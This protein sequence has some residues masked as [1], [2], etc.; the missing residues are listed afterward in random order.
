MPLVLIAVGCVIAVPGAA[1]DRTAPRGHAAAP[2]QT[3]RSKSIAR[4]SQFA[5][6]TPDGS[7]LIELYKAART[8]A[9][10]EGANAKVKDQVLQAQSVTSEL[11][12]LHAAKMTACEDVDASHLDAT[13]AKATAFSSTL[14]RIEHEIT[15]SLSTM[16]QKVIPS[17]RSRLERK[18]T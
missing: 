2:I 16:R 5:D 18:T 4:L 12:R 8:V 13:A 3:V 15:K 14:I 9:D 17:D 11:V 6:L 7:Q 10:V 1:E